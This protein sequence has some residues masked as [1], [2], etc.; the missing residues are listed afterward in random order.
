[1]SSLMLSFCRPRA[2]AQGL[3]MVTIVQHPVLL[4]VWLQ[5]ELVCDNQR[6]TMLMVPPTTFSL[7]FRSRRPR[8]DVKE[9]KY[10][11][12]G[13]LGYG[14]DDAKLSCVWDDRGGSTVS[15]RIRACVKPKLSDHPDQEAKRKKNGHLW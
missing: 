15:E 13:L 14:D 6:K 1:M 8:T 7:F 10:F 5:F 3:L 4:W 2:S 9:G 12:N 11:G